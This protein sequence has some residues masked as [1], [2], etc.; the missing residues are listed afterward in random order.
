MDWVW[1]TRS[2]RKRWRC[3]SSQK[4]DEGNQGSIL[5]PGGHNYKEEETLHGITEQWMRLH[6]GSPSWA[7]AEV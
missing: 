7:E 5:A 3:I 6:M 1:A 2:Q 4:V